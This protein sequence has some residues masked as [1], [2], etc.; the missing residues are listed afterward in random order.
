[1]SDF[2][3][4]L[5]S[6]STRTEF[7][8]NVSNSFKIRLPQPIRL[9]GD[10]WKVGLTSISLPD[11]TALMSLSRRI[12]ES[13]V[14][15]CSVLFKKGFVRVDMKGDEVNL[16]I[17]FDTDDLQQVLVETTGVGLM[18][19][20]LAHLRQSRLLADNGPNL[21]SKYLKSTSSGTKRTYFDFKWEGDELVTNNKDIDVALIPPKL[22]INVELAKLMGWLTSDGEKLG[23]NLNMELFDDKTVPDLLDP[24]RKPDL[25]D[26]QKRPVFWTTRARFLLLSIHCN[27]RFLYFNRPLESMWENSARS[28]FVYSVVCSSGVVGSQVTDLLQEVNY[29]RSSGGYQFCE[30]IHVQ[31]IPLRKDE[32]DIIEVQV[33]ET[34]GKL[35]RFDEGVTILTLHFKRT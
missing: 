24:A 20:A 29:T 22:E 9:E 21:K 14:A 28:L 32:M 7:P 10:G 4:T 6:D 27:W 1:M 15:S 18:K 23:P 31:Y 8:D 26:E 17:D 16:L 34:T 12:C 5:P 30:P 3:I 2:Y 35:T 19:S 13:N 33:S 25:L 11:T